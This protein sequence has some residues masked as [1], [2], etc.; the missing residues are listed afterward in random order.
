MKHY[1]EHFIAMLRQCEAYACGETYVQRGHP[2][3]PALC[4]Q[5][6]PLGF[7]RAGA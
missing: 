2:N 5:H 4:L 6:V 3:A 1:D 7:V